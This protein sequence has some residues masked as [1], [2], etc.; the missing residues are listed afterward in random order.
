MVQY[1]AK[2][3]RVALLCS[4]LSFRRIRRSTIPGA[5]LLLLVPYSLAQAN[6]P[7][8]INGSQE[9]MC[10]LGTYHDSLDLAF[11]RATSG[12]GETA[13]AVQVLPSFHREYELVVKQV[14]SQLRVLRARFQTQLWVELTPLAAPRTRQECLDLAATA[15]LDTVALSIPAETTNQ[16]LSEFGSIKLSETYRCPRRGRQCAL[17]SDGTEYVVISRD[18]PRAHITETGTSKGIT[19]ENPALLDWIHRLLRVANDPQL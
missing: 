7:T 2:M 3:R 18:G 17:F 6:M 19:N 1:I 16:L 4:W 13:L 10:G 14:N 15:T 8:W 11:E 9:R 12:M 5:I